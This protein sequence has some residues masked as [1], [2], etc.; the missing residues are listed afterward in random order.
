MCY[1]CKSRR[2]LD[3]AHERA[4]GPALWCGIVGTHYTY[5]VYL[6]VCMHVCVCECIYIYTYIIVMF[7]FGRSHAH[8]KNSIFTPSHYS[9]RHVFYDR[10]ATL[11]NDPLKENNKLDNRRSL[12][13]HSR[14]I[15]TMRNVRLSK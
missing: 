2:L 1:L 7:S 4:I 13:F 12:M 10:A 11:F 5:I 14:P 8:V 6:C 15:H 3:I 9:G